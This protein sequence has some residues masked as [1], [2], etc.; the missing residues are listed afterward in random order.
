MKWAFWISVAVIAYTYAGYPLWLYL[1]NCWMNRPVSAAQIQP[2]IS[3]VL[4]VH[5]ESSTIAE[6]LNNLSQLS[7]PSELIEMIIVSDGSTD[8][9]A[10]LLSPVANKRMI[11]ISCPQHVGKGRG[12]EPRHEHCPRRNRR[13]HG[14]QTKVREGC[15]APSHRKFPRLYS[16][17]RE[18]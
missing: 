17:M 3:L 8:G 13:F 1:C 6:K 12:V 11:V 15:F 4:A 7:Y 16:G 5:N 10:E 2:T 18:R 9:T 14:C